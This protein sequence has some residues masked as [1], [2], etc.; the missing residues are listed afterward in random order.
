MS[1]SVLPQPPKPGQTR[2]AVHRSFD[3]R[4]T[5]RP[6]ILHE[7][8]Q[9]HK[10]G[11]YDRAWELYQRLDAESVARGRGPHWHGRMMAA[12]LWYQRT[13]KTDF[14]VAEDLPDSFGAN[15]RNVVDM[16]KDVSLHLPKWSDPVY[17]RGVILEGLG[18]IDEAAHCFQ[19]ALE[20]DNAYAEAWVNLGNCKLHQGDVAAAR[21]CFEIAET[22]NPDDALA[23][24]NLM[25]ALALFGEWEEAY[26]RYEYRYLVPG[27]L[28]DN[29]LP[30]LVPQW[31]GATYVDRLIVTDEQGAGDIIQFS[32][33]LPY[34][35]ARAGQVFCRVRHPHLIPWLSANFPR[36]RFFSEKDRVPKGD[37]HVPLL[38]CIS[39]LR[40]SE[41]EVPTPGGYLA[42]TAPTSV[43]SALTMGTTWQLTT[44]RTTSLAQPLRVGVCWAGSPTHKRD[45]V[46][47]IPWDTFK[48]L[49]DV[50]NV[51]F[52]NLT[53]G[54]RAAVSHPA[55]VSPTYADY[56]ATALTMSG[57][58]LVISVDTSA[59]HAAGALGIPCWLLIGASPDMRWALGRD[60][61][62]F[63][64]SIILHRQQKHDDWPSVI[65]VVKDKLAD[66][67]CSDSTFRSSSVS[68]TLTGGFDGCSTS[69]NDQQ[70]TLIS[71][72]RRFL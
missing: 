25:H 64:R 66:L 22:L 60:D 58:D 21:Q 63:Y 1:A 26:Q 45:A 32:R 40:I 54:E 6:D 46:R 9:N 12:L 33:F 61:T 48:P 39:R 13:S 30:R 28:R 70:N 16:L 27:H 47:S 65:A 67:T 49:L 37:A 3:P 42:A 17:N 43:T 38:S 14:L 29:G 62:P 50:P 20:I 19:R 8:A 11:N 4:L 35:E 23:K 34:L 69:P 68:S 51:Q 53:V 36:V 5:Y 7:A 59:A 52:V 24:Y 44:T 18:R 10:A 57:L 72:D 71:D 55:L 56:A 31:D 2:R 15:Y 41:A